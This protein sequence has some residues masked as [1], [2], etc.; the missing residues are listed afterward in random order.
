MKTEK[1]NKRKT[2]K[3]R[4][5]G[6][7]SGSVLIIMLLGPSFSFADPALRYQRASN[8]VERRDVRAGGRIENRQERQ[9]NRIERR[10][11]RV[12]GRIENQQE[13]S[14]NRIERRDERIT[15]RIERRDMFFSPPAGATAVSV[16][17]VQGYKVGADVYKPAIYEGET[18]YVKANGE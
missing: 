7:V 14:G 10:D 11:V 15:N 8:R 5:M 9:G 17:G 1:I 13:R 4:W 16:E 18:V 6:L 12:G 3:W 2:R